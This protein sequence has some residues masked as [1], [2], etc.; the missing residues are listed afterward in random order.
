MPPEYFIIE[1]RQ[2]QLEEIQKASKEKKRADNGSE[3]VANRVGTVGAVALDKHGNLAAGTSTGGLANKLPGRVGD[4]AVIGAG[5]Y[6]NNA[7]CAVSGTG[8]G[9]FFIRAS[10]AR[11]IASLVEYKKMPLK[12]AADTVVMKTLTDMKAEAGIIALDGRGN[13]ATPYNTEGMFR[14]SIRSDGQR[15]IAIYEK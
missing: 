6:A 1:G 10:A 7:T 14:G 15:I 13:V 11:D 12:E 2:K 4:S 8:Q 5:T 9:E 3:R